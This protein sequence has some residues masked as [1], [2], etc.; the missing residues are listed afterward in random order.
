MFVIAKSRFEISRAESIVDL[1]KV[2]GFIG[3]HKQHRRRINF[4]YISFKH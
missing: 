1:V 2:G 3:R 4:F